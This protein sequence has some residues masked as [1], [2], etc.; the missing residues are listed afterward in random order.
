MHSYQ[1]FLFYYS[2]IAATVLLIVCLFFI[3]KP[4]NFFALA[5][6]VPIPLYFWLLITL[7]EE[8]S[9]HRWSLKML[10]VLLIVGLLGIFAFWLAGKT[11]NQPPKTTLQKTIPL[12]AQT[13][14]GEKN[15]KSLKDEDIKKFL[16][17]IKTDLSQIKA[18]QR[19]TREILG[20]S[21]SAK[22]IA[23]IINTILEQATGSSLLAP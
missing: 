23:N 10:S 8:K 15:D 17:E 7:S 20:I 5:L 6:F 9:P 13:V 3:P 12:P 11:P 1:K 18:E 14:L 21:G 4:Q 22:D 16:E 19:A 2:L